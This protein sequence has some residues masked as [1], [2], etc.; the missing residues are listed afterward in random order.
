MSKRTLAILALF[1]ANLFWGMGPV[2][3]KIGLEEISPFSLAF[4]RTLLSLVILLPFVFLTNNH[5]V[6]KEDI[7]QLLIVGLF[8]SGLNAI[9]FLTG[10]SKTS[11]TAASSIFATVPLVN[12]VAASFI[13]KEKPTLIRILGVGVG[14]LGSIIIAFG[15]A[16]G[17]T[18]ASGDVFGNILIVGAV[19]SWVA[20][21]I[22]SKQVLKKYPPVTVVAFSMI[23]GVL[24]LF[25]LFIFDL[26]TNPY[27]YSQIGTSGLISI[28]YGGIINGVFSFL[29]FQFGMQYT[30]AFEAGIMIYLNPLITDIFAVALLGEKLSQIF[31]IG[32]ILILC[33]VF[34]SSTYELI[35]KRREE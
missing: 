16:L 25:P 35:K 12:A 21:I 22:G 19:F 5:R 33:G 9:F 8:G 18:G 29:L 14:F 24:V 17:K 7:K 28:L 31:I 27:Q 20:Y 1:G 4:L 32:S 3:T 34:L 15:P 26:I 10:I 2:V 23:S 30:S 6:K 13:L 11:A